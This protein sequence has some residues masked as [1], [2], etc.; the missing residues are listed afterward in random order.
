[1]HLD[2]GD[3]EGLGRPPELKDPQKVPAL[4]ML[5]QESA[6]HEHAVLQEWVQKVVPQLLVHLGLWSA[7]GL[8]AAAAARLVRLSPNAHASDTE[9]ITKLVAMPDQSLAV[10]LVNAALG[11]WTVVD[12]ADLD[13][14]QRRL[15]LA[16]VTLHD[17]NKLVGDE[18][19]LNP[20]R[21]S[22]YRTALLEWGEQLGLWQFIDRAHWADV[23]FLAANA[24]ARRGENRTLPNYPELRTDP[25]ILEDVSLYVRLADLLAS[26]CRR[27]EDAVLHSGSDP[28]PALI[29][30]GLRH[31]GQY[32]LRYHKTTENRG[33]LTQLIHDA[34]LTAARSAGWIPLLYFPDGVTYLAPKG[35]G[36]PEV[37]PLAA[38]VRAAV[39]DTAQVRADD[40]V[41]RGN[42]GIMYEPDLVQILDPKRAAEVLITRTFVKISDGKPVVTD[43]RKTKTTLRPDSA[44][45]LDFSYAGSLNADRLAEGMIGIGKLLAD[46]YGGD[47]PV[48]GEAL[49]RTLAM[50]DFLDAYRGIAWTGG[51]G[52]PWYYV[53][54]HYC[55]RH[56]GLLPAE[57]EERMAA[58]AHSVIAQLGA[59]K[60]GL[61]F[62]FLDE[63]IPCVLSVGGSTSPWDF[64]GELQKY[65]R[66]KARGGKPICAVCNSPFA[67]RADFSAYT[68]KKTAG[69]KVPSE[70]GICAVCQAEE[71]MR[72][73]AFGQSGRGDDGTK[74]LHLYPA[75]FFTPITGAAM[76]RAYE[77]LKQVN[78]S[79]V[80]R[81][82]GS[83]ATLEALARSDV[84]Y[85]RGD[86]DKRRPLERVQ[87]GAGQ[88]HAYYLV[89]VPYSGRTPS[90]TENWLMPALL[91]LLSP[92]LLAVKVVVSGSSLPI[93]GSG[94]DFAATVI[95]DGPHAFWQHGM[96]R[97]YYR[98]DELAPA[99]LAACALYGLTSDA[100]RDGSGFPVWN[101]IGSVARALE[102]DPLAVFHYADRIHAAQNKARRSGKGAAAGVMAETGGMSPAM[103]RRLTR[104]HQTLSRYD[105]ELELGRDDRMGVV[106]GIVDRYT[107]FYRAEGF[108]AYARL[109]PLL[110]AADVILD[111]SPADCDEDL[112]LMIQGALQAF[113]DRVRNP[114]GAQ[115]FI[116]EGAR[117]TAE[118]APLVAEFARYMLAE[119]FRGYCG[120]DRVVLRQRLNRLM[121]GCEAYYVLW[122]LDRRKAQENTV[123]E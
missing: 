76:R 74:F 7:K 23:A 31:R 73:F 8:S 17:L 67:S 46:F 60:T 24:E 36:T 53:A 41:R 10:H 88:M 95:L 29:R 69:P 65:Q 63:Y 107:C 72:R 47:G 5:I 2:L 99:I 68:N 55:R 25:A 20:G 44:V 111:S 18:I 92:L 9:R 26:V 16:G 59:P 14:W 86:A 64:A 97:T 82:L 54:G 106:K 33:L 87:Y 110:L 100:Y 123:K 102:T 40:L 39:M 1:M 105:Q 96:R 113:L 77:H 6:E 13:D 12:L 119:V 49:V 101:Q 83:D 78:F 22:E 4:T 81:A 35:A 27:P 89:G 11:A 38:V 75:Y 94:A 91:A 34:F 42:F 43:E 52:Y 45:V 115:G 61:P 48:R 50:D 114:N 21:E 15:Y 28:I 117:K 32:E 56:P 66:N 98:L 19:F 58:A 62:A 121:N 37:A 108:A 122:D 116:P 70:R 93:Y 57:L 90:E 71:L 112:H 120:G 118:A 103:A 80:A 30:R 79:D 51:V 109:R 85:I 104:Y 3:A 84:F